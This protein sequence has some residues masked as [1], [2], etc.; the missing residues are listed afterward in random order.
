MDE[1]NTSAGRRCP[2]SP[3]LG[4]GIRLDISVFEVHGKPRICDVLS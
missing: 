2:H 1:I 4:S 3:F